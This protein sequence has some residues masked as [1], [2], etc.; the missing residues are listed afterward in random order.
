MKTASLSRRAL[1]ACNF[2]AS[3]E[4]TRYYLMGVYVKIGAR[5]TEY[6]ATDGHVLLAY[7]E[8]LHEDSPDNTLTGEFII[9]SSTCADKNVKGAK[10]ADDATELAE[11]ADGFLR[12]NNALVFKPI[13]GTFPDWRRIVPRK[14]DGEAAQF[15]PALLTRL[16]KAGVLFDCQ[17]PAIAHNSD[18][19]ALV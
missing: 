15:N 1:Q 5:A 11:M 18:S 8:E 2:A 6:C 16:Q 13:D 9:P 10:W 7:R 12:L 14:I 19:P 17:I 4:E 3:K